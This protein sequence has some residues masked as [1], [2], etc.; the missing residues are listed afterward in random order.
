VDEE[1]LKQ[2]IDDTLGELETYV[3]Q[4]RRLRHTALYRGVP[5]NGSVFAVLR[6][7]NVL[8]GDARYRRVGELWEAFRVEV[9][10]TVHEQAQTAERLAVGHARFTHVLVARALR[11]LE[12]DVPRAQRPAVV[13]EEAGDGNLCL[14]AADAPPL[15]VV[16]LLFAGP[17]AD[18]AERLPAA[19]D[20]LVVHAHR[21]D[22]PPPGL[23]ARIGDM[24]FVETSP[25]D[26]NAVEAVGYAIHSHV[27]CARL[28]TLPPEATVSGRLGD[29][30]ERL[31]LGESVP[32][33]GGALYVV[34]GPL[35][36]LNSELANERRRSPRDRAAARAFALDLDEA[37]RQ[38]RE[39]DARLG[40]ALA[41]P[42]PHC[43]G[44]GRVLSHARERYVIEC[45]VRDC[46]TRWGVQAC[47][48]CARGLPFFTLKDMPVTLV[49]A[50]SHGVTGAQAVFGM[51][52]LG[53]LELAG[54]ELAVR[55]SCG[56]AQPVSVT[57]K[58]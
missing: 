37:G 17:S 6:R 23:A 21:D 10:P 9:P 12:W 55:C 7:T 52:A 47:S 46:G 58:Q 11:A 42:H 48:A 8:R 24:W 54:E 13:V 15:T 28:G 26:L 51:L 25:L 50:G 56:H 43:Q 19:S 35:A 30:P 29:L 4:V 16:P 2:Q 27:M 36:N 5:R 32:R 1:D 22:E 33:P 53:E 18:L 20:T 3:R 40:R 14:R 34:P 45:T 39:A 31:R 38:L 41:C 44:V 49:K 57:S